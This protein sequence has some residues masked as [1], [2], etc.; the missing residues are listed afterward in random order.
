MEF[1]MTSPCSQ[2]PF[3]K[4]NGYLTKARAKEIGT[5]LLAG[6][7]FSCHK[8]NSFDGEGDPVETEDTQHCAGALIFL[9]CQG[10]PN[11][12]MR[13]M[14]RIGYY[15]REKLNMLAPVARNLRELVAQHGK[16]F[17]CKRAGS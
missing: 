14:E 15:D 3:L 8:T 7:T 13:W 12:M 11:Q 5:A 4:S 17:W 2:C 16:N 10:R 9:E 1:T 6:K